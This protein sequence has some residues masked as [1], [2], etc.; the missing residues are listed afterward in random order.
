MVDY[1]HH[2]AAQNRVNIGSGNDLLPNRHQGIMWYNVV[3]C[4]LDPLEQ[5]LS[6]YES[7]LNVFLSFEN[8]VCK[9]SAILHMSQCVS[10]Q[11]DWSMSLAVKA[12]LNN[13]QY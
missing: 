8:V 4:Q 3:Y 7:K 5:S 6:K 12:V 9:M 10:N 1:W 2:I 11:P 13:T